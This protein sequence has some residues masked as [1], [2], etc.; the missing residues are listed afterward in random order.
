MSGRLRQHIEV[1]V[2]MDARWRHPC[3]KPVEPLQ[4]RQD[5]L[6]VPAWTLFGALVEQMLGIELAQPVQGQRWPGTIVQQPLTSGTVSGRDAHRG[7]DGEADPVFPLHHRLPVI[8]RQ[9]A[10]GAPTRA[11]AAGARPPALARWLR[12][13]LVDHLL[14][15]R[16]VGVDHRIELAG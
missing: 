14:V 9:R 6:A 2:A 12:V 16:L 15:D 10:G 3:R 4:R 13:G 8:A 1:A 5:P 7:A 11:T